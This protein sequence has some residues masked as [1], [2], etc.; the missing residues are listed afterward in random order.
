VLVLIMLILGT[1]A[2]RLWPM[3]FPQSTAQVVT[4][5]G[6]IEGRDVTLAAKVIQGRVTKL[7]V[8]EGERV[9][10]GQLLAELDAA[11][12]EAQVAAARAGVSALDAQVSQASLDVA[13]TAKRSDASIAAAEAALSS[14]QAHAARAAAVRANSSAVYARSD[15]L[16]RA[17]AISKQDLDVAEMTLRTSEADVAAAEKDVTRAS[18]DLALAGASVDTVGLK[19]QQLRALE[20]SRRTATARLAEADANLAERLIVAPEDGTVVSRVVEVGDV[21]SPGAPLFHVVDMNRLYLKV[22][23]PEPDIAKLRL[24]DTADIIVDAFP[25][26]RFPARVSKIYQQAEFTPKNVETTEER[27]KLVFGVELTVANT[28]GLLKPGMPADGV[29]HWTPPPEP[30]RHGS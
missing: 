29:I 16:F 2:G 17:G 23:V 11:Q 7:M 12:F 18:A 6:R 20:E 5:S 21:V 24:G 22:Y 19:R 9:T 4:A 3:L 30:T 10:K 1:I 15:V 28:D 27:L 26:R 13:Y 14:A 8:D 25:T